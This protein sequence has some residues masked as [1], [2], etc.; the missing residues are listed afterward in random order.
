MSF[1]NLDVFGLGDLCFSFLTGVSM[2]IDAQSLLMLLIIML[3][4]YNI[5][6]LINSLLI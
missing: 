1:S 6:T 3:G 2:S 4:T 5:T